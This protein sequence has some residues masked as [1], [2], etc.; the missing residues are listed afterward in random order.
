MSSTS[1]ANVGQHGSIVHETKDSVKNDFVWITW[2]SIA[3]LED[4]NVQEIGKFAVKEYNEKYKE[5]FKCKCIKYG[6]YTEL[7]EHKQYRFL[8]VKENDRPYYVDEQL[9]DVIVSETYDFPKV[10]KL[11]LFMRFFIYND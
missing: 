8:L 2:T 10:K 1:I 4:P 11:V 6:W 5:H 3:N 7:K 9:Y